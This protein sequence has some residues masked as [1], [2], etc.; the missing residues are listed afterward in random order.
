MRFF[1]SNQTFLQNYRGYVVKAWAGYYFYYDHF[2]DQ[3]QQLKHRIPA[4]AD[5]DV[6]LFDQA[7]LHEIER[8]HRF[9]LSLLDSLAA[10]LE[11]ITSMILENPPNQ[12]DPDAD[13]NIEVSI[14]LVYQKINQT[15][16]FYKLNFF[17]ISKI[18]K[19][20]DKLLAMTQPESMNEQ[21]A[22]STHSDVA[23]CS[24]PSNLEAAT[25]SLPPLDPVLSFKGHNKSD[26][27]RWALL[28]GGEYFYNGFVCSG[29]EIQKLRKQCIALYGQKFRRTFGHLSS[30]ELVYVKNK[31]RDYKSTRVVVGIKFGLI[32]CI[33]AWFISDSTTVNNDLDFWNQAGLFVFTTIGNFLLYRLTWAFNVYLW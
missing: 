26:T 27:A 32:A 12:Q 8:V 29:D 7:V 28:S 1:G 30:Y 4:P 13:H 19:K 11:A 15:E 3:Y 24:V 21:G 23:I 18:A 9:L 31:D 20:I 22:E 14:R 25:I 33:F 10:D 6:R 2:K 17:A 16:E 5:S